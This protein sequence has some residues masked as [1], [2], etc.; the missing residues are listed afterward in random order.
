MRLWFGSSAIVILFLAS[1]ASVDAQAK[2]N[3]RPQTPTPAARA[4]PETT[5]TPDR[6]KRNERPPADGPDARDEQEPKPDANSPRYRYEFTQ[7]DFIVSRIVIEHDD[8]GKGTI[9]FRRRSFDDDLTEPITVS[10][11]SLDVL[12][13]A[14]D[15]LNFVD[16]TEDY[17]FER[18]LSNMGNIAITLKRDGKERTAKYN[19]TSN[20]DAKILMDEYRRL[21][22]QFVWVFDFNLAREN[23]PLDTP[24]LV[25]SLDGLLKRNEIADPVQML[26][27]LVSVSNDERV[28]LIGRNRAGKLVKQIEKQK[29]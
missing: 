7:P 26:P 8:S 13:T 2:R 27:F 17:Q 22:N 16:S 4:T 9:A 15:A 14:F 21:A 12:R 25:E 3:S 20:K 29:N 1:A 24:K 23:Q 6:P 28:P 19:W 11:K 10:S 18:D 5:P